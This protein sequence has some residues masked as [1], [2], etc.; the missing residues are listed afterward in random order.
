MTIASKKYDRAQGKT[1]A[2]TWQKPGKNVAKIRRTISGLVR[3]NP[4]VISRLHVIQQ[5]MT[6]DERARLRA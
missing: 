5:D 3:V 4:F 6:R 2:K 1:M